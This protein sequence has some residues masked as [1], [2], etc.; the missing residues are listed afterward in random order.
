M[1]ENKFTPESAVQI[2]PR[3]DLIKLEALNNLVNPLSRF[4][5]RLAKANDDQVNL[6]VAI[7][8]F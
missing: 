3:M 2:R 7:N 5:S 1:S 6:L 8:N 4:E